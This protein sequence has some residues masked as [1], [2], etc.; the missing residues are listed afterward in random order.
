MVATIVLASVVVASPEV[1]R[2]TDSVAGYSVK[3]RQVA[4][5]Q[6]RDPENGY[7]VWKSLDCDG[8]HV[9]VTLTRDR[10]MLGVA[11]HPGQKSSDGS[12]ALRQPEDVPTRR[13]ALATKNGVRIGMRVDQ[14]EDR[15]GAPDRVARKG[16]SN[17]FLCYLYRKITMED[18]ERG[19]ALRNT[20]VFKNGVVIEIQIHGD[21]IP[22]CGGDG[23]DESWWP[24][25]RFGEGTQP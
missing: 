4:N 18:K 5:T 16:W 13:L 9:A 3:G 21:G 23:R 14:V 1:D 12:Y 10:E 20:Y 7:Y 11:R 8:A 19:Y 25:G 15:I 22:G 2:V 24:T 6:V 17:Q